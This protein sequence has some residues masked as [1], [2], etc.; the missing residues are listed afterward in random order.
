RRTA[1]QARAAVQAAQ[2]AVDVAK[3]NLEWCRVTAPVAGKVSRIEITPGNLITGGNAQGT[4]LTSITS[5]DPIYCYVNIDE[6]AVR[7]YQ[8]VYREQGRPNVREAGL[9]CQLRVGDSGTFDI[10][11]RLDFVDNRI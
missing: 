8:R 10:D 11:G 6:N 4:L 1:E 7:R 3:L 2:A 9:P 5:V